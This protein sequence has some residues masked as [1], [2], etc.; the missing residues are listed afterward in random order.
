[1]FSR[2]CQPLANSQRY[3]LFKLSTRR[4]L[5]DVARSCLWNERC[6]SCRMHDVPCQH[7]IFR[8]NSGG[9][10][11]PWAYL[12]RTSCRDWTMCYGRCGLHDVRCPKQN[13]FCD[14][15]GHEYRANGQNQNPSTKP[16]R[17]TSY[18]QEY[19]SNLANPCA[20]PPNCL[21]QIPNTGEVPEDWRKVNGAPIFKKGESYSASNYGSI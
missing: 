15:I 5:R 20:H 19:R 4:R 10:M 6:T 17:T 3:E 11:V 18:T 8:M 16:K 1:M 7:R 13:Q 14:A 9:C 12:L 21:C 2:H